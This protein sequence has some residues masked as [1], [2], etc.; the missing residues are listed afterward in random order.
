MVKVIKIPLCVNKKNGQINSYFKQNQLPKE[1][2]DNIK[3]EAGSVKKLLV[4]FEGWE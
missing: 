3:K 2:T 4:S 1:V